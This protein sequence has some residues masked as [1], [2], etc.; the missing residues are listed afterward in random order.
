MTS[1]RIQ[2]VQ[3]GSIWFCV[4]YIDTYWFNGQRWINMVKIHFDWSYSVHIGTDL[5][6][7]NLFKNDSLVSKPAYISECDSI[8]HALP[9]IYRESDSFF[10]INMF[11][12][13]KLYAEKYSF[14]ST[15]V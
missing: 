5:H 11:I 7:F 6:W 4:V 14:D 3:T 2:W 9:V 1:N 12:I 13:G 15:K 8:C 10:Q